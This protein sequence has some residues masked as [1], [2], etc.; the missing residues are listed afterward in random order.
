MKQQADPTKSGLS[1][2]GLLPPLCLLIAAGGLLGMSLARQQSLRADVSRDRDSDNDGLVDAQEIVLGTSCVSADTDLDG[3]SDLEELA[4]QTSPVAAQVHPDN[5]QD[6]SLGVGMSCYWA[7]GK[8]R[9]TIAFYLPDRNVHDK[10]FRV[11]MLIGNQFVMLPTPALIARGRYETYPARD[12]RAMIAVLDLPISPSLVHAHGTVT[13]FATAGYTE[14]G[15][16][17]AADA[18]Q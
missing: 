2:L 6:N 17:A 7:N 16:V 1:S 5:D 12:P 11:G 10:T 9:T 8:V 4:R 15:V 3:Y 14:R 13:V 18:A